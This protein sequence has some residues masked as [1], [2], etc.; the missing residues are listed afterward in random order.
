MKN[1][2]A[3]IEVSYKPTIGRKPMIKSSYDAYTELKAFYP[4]ET[5][6]LQEQFVVM[7][8]NRATRVLGIY[9]SS[10][11]GITGTSVDIRLILS[12]ALKTAAT[13]IIISHNHPSGNL[14]PSIADKE[15]T[16][17]IK[18]AAKLLDITLLDH[19]IITKEDFLSFEDKGLNN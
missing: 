10:K 6:E 3:E 17:K 16:Q 4:D 11:G 8:L 9:P 18:N 14:Y 12:V 13:S 5:I 15:L 7:Y 1:K 2:V 19:I